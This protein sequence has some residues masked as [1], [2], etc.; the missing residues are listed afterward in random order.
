MDRSTVIVG[1]VLL[2]SCAGFMVLAVQF[3]SPSPQPAP[4]M[5][6]ALPRSVAANP[7]A[8]AQLPDG[9]PNAAR[10]SG[11]DEFGGDESG[12][13]EF[14]GDE[15][16]GDEFGGNGSNIEAMGPDDPPAELAFPPDPPLIAAA[17]DVAVALST[18]LVPESPSGTPSDIAVAWNPAPPRPARPQL[19][20]APAV[21]TAT[22]EHQ[23]TMEPTTAGGPESWPVA[24]AADA[25]E[26]EPDGDEEPRMPSVAGEDSLQAAHAPVTAVASLPSGDERSRRERGLAGMPDGQRWRNVFTDHLGPEPQLPAGAVASRK[27]RQ[28]AE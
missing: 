27:A 20:S 17:D 8:L 4:P 5:L 10:E 15:F 26:A 24:D 28:N 2:I 9:Q 22:E 11:G 21:A 25:P 13:D 18:P 14:G 19:A 1:G 23:P 16:G 7:R 3:W 12:G 6:G